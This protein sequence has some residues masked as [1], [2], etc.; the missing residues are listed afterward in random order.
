V[1]ESKGEAPALQETHAGS[2]VLYQIVY[3]SRDDLSV[4]WESKFQHQYG[5]LRD[6]VLKTF[7]E[8]LNY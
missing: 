5:C 1:G 4:Q 7:D 8:Y 2:T 3:H 6:E